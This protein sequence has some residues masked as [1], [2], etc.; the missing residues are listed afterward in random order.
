MR[1]RDAASSR[2]R[3]P[4]VRGEIEPLAADELVELPEDADADL[5]GVAVAVLN[6]GMATRFGGAVKHLS[7]SAGV[8]CSTGCSTASA[9]STRSTASI[10]SMNSRFAPHFAAVG[11]AHDVSS[12][13][14]HDSERRPARAVGDLQ[15]GHRRLRGPRAGTNCSSSR[16]TTSSSCRYRSSQPGARVKPQPASAVPLHDVGDFELADA[17]RDRD[18]RRATAASSSS[19]RSRASRRR[20]S[21]RR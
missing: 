9:S 8:R 20:R 14:R 11:G 4:H 2:R 3:R 21:P 10:S 16:A 17:L 19:S 5:D 13:R 6:G 15:P 7:P 1:V 12:T 18:D